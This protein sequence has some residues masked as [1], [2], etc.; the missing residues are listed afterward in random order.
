LR[1]LPKHSIDAVLLD[2][3]G[4]TTPASFVHDT[5]FPYARSRIRDF[6]LKERAEPELPALRSEYDADSSQEKPPWRG[7]SGAALRRS[8]AAFLEFLMSHDRKSPALKTIQGKIWKEG[9][10]E[11]ALRGEVYS[12]VAPALRRWQSQGRI[13]AIFS[14]G[15]VLAQKLL[16]ATTAAGDLRPWLAAYF[17][18]NAG[19]KTEPES[20]GRIARALPLE[21]SSV[22]FV[23]DTPSELRAAR[24]AGM[25][26]VLC[27]RA[28]DPPG[29]I[30]CPIVTTFDSL[31][32]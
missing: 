14:S 6:V 30:E 19:A 8:A 24:Q 27:A 9:Y 3:E 21:P 18:T 12:D 16:F 2:V 13:A 29:P 20:Y 23:S 31:F 25:E 32:P 11:G 7:D 28:G 5:L 1:I 4:T 17:D 15:S 22:L 10:E 26:V